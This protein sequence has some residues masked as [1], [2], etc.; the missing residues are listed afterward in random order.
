MEQM[1]NS[2][3]RSSVLQLIHCTSG[4]PLVRGHRLLVIA[5]CP[6]L[7]L[8]SCGP[9]DGTTPVAVR[10]LSLQDLYPTAVTL[11]ED[12][13]EDAYLVDAMIPFDTGQPDAYRHANLVFRSPST[14]IIGLSLWYDPET[15][16]WQD[17]WLSIA[18][19]D[20][21]R[22]PEIRQ[23]DWSIDS[24]EA[25]EIAQA[26]GGAEFLAGR[27]SGEL[28]LRLRLK[29]EQV[30]E[31]QLAVWKAMYRHRGTPDYLFVV[32]DTQTGEVLNVEDSR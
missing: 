11:A 27:P 7:L 6:V 29:T 4:M 17:E 24:L 15:G 2:R 3:L 1:T 23:S 32:I 31:R 10:T 12:W 16:S 5:L 21:Q 18:K 20:P 30:A 28:Y 22:E 14:D 25:L 19:V 9:Q 13:K 8:A 26:H